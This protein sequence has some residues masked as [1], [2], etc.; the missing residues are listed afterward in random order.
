[1][2]SGSNDGITRLVVLR[3]YHDVPANGDVLM[4]ELC[5]R[6]SA[7]TRLESLT[8]IDGT[9][10]VRGE[11][12]ALRLR[13]R[14]GRPGPIGPE[15]NEVTG[16]IIVDPDRWAAAE[17]SIAAGN[18][19]LYGWSQE[20]LLFFEG[21]RYLGRFWGLSDLD[22]E[23]PDFRLAR[24]TSAGETPVDLADPAEWRRWHRRFERA[25]D[26]GADF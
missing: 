5:L 22:E 11:A 14:A 8:A 19:I 16:A 25:V 6:A 9:R 18:T 13:R 21:E 17:G 12:E 26:D 15:T 23:I 10:Y 1:M 4:G 2:T 20:V 24:L 7:P 3:E